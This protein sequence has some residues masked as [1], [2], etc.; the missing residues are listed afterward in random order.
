LRGR[1]QAT[2]QEDE[3][4]RQAALAGVFG[5]GEEVAVVSSVAAVLVDS[6]QMTEKLLPVIQRTQDGNLINIDGQ[7]FGRLADVVGEGT[8]V[9]ELWP[10]T[11]EMF[12]ELLAGRRL[13]KWR[14]DGLSG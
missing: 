7:T 13:E 6:V 8:Y 2:T 5:D 4:V 1:E 12:N 11:E 3:E 14:A 9:G 10:I